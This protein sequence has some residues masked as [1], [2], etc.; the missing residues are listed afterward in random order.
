MSLDEY[1]RKRNPARTPEPAAGRRRGGGKQPVFVVQRHD[2]RRLH[3]DLRLEME[4]TLASWA[5]PKGLPLEP[6]EKYLAVHV[7]DHPMEYAD[8]S[9]VIPKGQYGAGTM[10]IWDRG[11]YELV[12]RKMDGYR[13]IARLAGGE[14]SLT[15]RGGNDMG[16]RFADI[17]RALPHALRTSD[18][19]VDGELCMLDERGRPD[20]GL[21]QRGEGSPAY[22]VFDLLEL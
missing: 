8:F 1:R 5:L 15:S 16:R 6:G 14:A 11:R 21:M 2:A 13:A 10:E 20:F 7:E 9:G 18:C 4:G 17:R 19:V 3:Y 12:E 22:Y